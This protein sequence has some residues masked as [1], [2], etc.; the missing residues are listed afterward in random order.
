[1][2]LVK[3][4]IQIEIIFNSGLLIG[5]ASLWRLVNQTIATKSRF[6][7]IRPVSEMMGYGQYCP[8]GFPYHLPLLKNNHSL[9]P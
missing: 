5:K 4:F 7:N 8:L 6:L 3:V 1:M 9:D 2:Q